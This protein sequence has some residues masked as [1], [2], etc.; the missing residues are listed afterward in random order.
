M[1]DRLELA[2][3]IERQRDP[4]GR[5]KVIIRPT[6]RRDPEITGMF[7]TR[8]EHTSAILHDYDEDQIALFTGFL[9]RP[10]EVIS[11][12]TRSLYG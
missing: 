4:A 1:L 9:R 2:G 10:N 12:M 7:S 11:Q 5:R 6:G 3:Q 8:A